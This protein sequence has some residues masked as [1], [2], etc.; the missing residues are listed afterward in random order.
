MLSLFTLDF[1]IALLLCASIS[2]L[3]ARIYVAM[4]CIT[5]HC[6]LVMICVSRV[7]GIY[8]GQTE[9]SAPEDN[10]SYPKVCDEFW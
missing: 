1:S 7:S 5:V 2:S 10:S 8:F 3:Y 9:L 4:A 6:K